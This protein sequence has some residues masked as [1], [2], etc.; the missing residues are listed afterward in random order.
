[1]APDENVATNDRAREEGG[2]GGVSGGDAGTDDPVGVLEPDVVPEHEAGVGPP[3]GGDQVAGVEAGVVL[4]DDVGAAV[5]NLEEP[6]S[7]VPVRR[8]H[9]DEEVVANGDPPGLLDRVHVV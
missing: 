2:E 7:P 8:P 3:V 5:E 1:M 6:S 9:V 4:D